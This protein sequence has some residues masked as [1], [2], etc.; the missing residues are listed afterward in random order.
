[1]LAIDPCLLQELQVL[2]AAPLYTLPEA[3]LRFV[4]SETYEIFLGPLYK[5]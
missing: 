1:M 2:I 4:G 5:K 3:D